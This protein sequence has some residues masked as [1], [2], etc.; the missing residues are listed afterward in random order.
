VER[1]DALVC[2]NM[3]HITPWVASEGLM[4]GA[5]RTLVAGGVLYLYGTTGNGIVRH[6][7]KLG[8]VCEYQ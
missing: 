4:A 8:G 3:I 1:A 2:I 5:K 6:Y 7:F